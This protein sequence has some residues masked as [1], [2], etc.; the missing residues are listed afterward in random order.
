M[1]Y[2]ATTKPTDW[3]YPSLGLRGNLVAD[4][5]LVSSAVQVR[6]NRYDGALIDTFTSANGVIADKV[7]YP[8][9]G[10]FL[11][12]YWQNWVSGAG[13]WAIASNQMTF[14]STGGRGLAFLDT[15]YPAAEN[16]GNRTIITTFT[17]TSGIAL[18][19]I[20][21]GDYNTARTIRVTVGGKIQVGSFTGPTTITAGTHTIRVV[22]TNTTLY[23]NCDVSIYLDGVLEGTVTIVEHASNSNTR[24]WYGVGADAAAVGLTF[25]RFEIEAITALAPT[26]WVCRNAAGTQVAS[27]SLSGSDT[28]V[29]IPDSSL[30][31]YASS[32]PYGFYHFL[33]YG[34]ARGGTSAGDRAFHDEWGDCYFSRLPTRTG[35]PAKPVL[36]DASSGD[37]EWDEPLH[38]YLALGPF[39]YSGLTPASS[40]SALNTKAIKADTWYRAFATAARP[41]YTLALFPTS[42][43]PNAANVTAIVNASKSYVNCWEPENEPH[44]RNSGEATT[45]V[46]NTLAPFYAA[47]K[48]AD[49]TALVMA[50]AITRIDQTA[51]YQFF[52]DAGGLAYC[53]AI[54]YHAYNEAQIDIGR[55]RRTLQDFKSFLTANSITKPVFQTEQGSLT[56]WNGLVQ[57][58]E[59][60]QDTS[61]QIFLQE[62]FGIPMERNS[63]WYDLAHGFDAF[64]GW[65]LGYWDHAVLAAPLTAANMAAELRDT[66]LAT[67]FDFNSAA[68]LYAGGHFTRADG[69]SVV[70]IIAQS[71]LLPTVDLYVTGA[72]VPLTY[73]DPWGNTRSLTISGGKV[74]V[75][76]FDRLVGW[77]RLPA[78]ATPSLRP[79]D[80]TWG[81]DQTR[82]T[83]GATISAVGGTVGVNLLNPAYIIDTTH[84]STGGGNYLLPTENKSSTFPQTYTIDLGQAR[85][86]DRIATRLIGPTAFTIATSA[87]DV[88]YVTRYTYSFTK[89]MDRY[90]G[91]HRGFWQRYARPQEAHVWSG[92]A[93]SARYVKL[94]VTAAMWAQVYIPSFDTQAMADEV[95]AT[96]TSLWPMSYHVQVPWIRAYQ[97]APPKSTVLIF[98][99]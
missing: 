60:A 71:N 15:Y 55:A 54:S 13:S 78:G 42:T 40:G 66:T 9:L 62:L 81:T 44:I 97:A 70:G 84:H 26:S 30:N 6:L 29:S 34:T 20:H 56:E 58:L 17:I 72:A 59:P 36:A 57:V 35:L 45:Y 28:S 90:A 37:P 82:S 47:V 69:T 22:V 83:Q 99:L 79:A 53:D 63:Y 19:N 85:T 4:G 75:P 77:V 92:T 32:G 64:P 12:Q 38:G 11:N 86:I 65:A 94:T 27:G 89:F 88:T 73:V 52:V 67:K 23:T 31:Q 1:T 43:Y 5:D 18:I 80:W 49:P 33:T 16:L 24:R 91:N 74:V 93:V 25:D 14:T 46:T 10:S 50:P 98:T 76:V 95:Y 7:R 3:L 96:N 48:A 8:E 51:D 87:D 61:I 21:N 2:N 39:R 68:D 41:R